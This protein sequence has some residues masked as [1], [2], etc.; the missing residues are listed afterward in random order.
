MVPLLTAA[1]NM[2]QHLAHGTSLVTVM[3]V[4]AAGLAGY[5]VTGNVDWSLAAWLALGSAVGAYF[6][7]VAM[8]RFPPRLLQFT[9]GLFLIAV[10]ARMFVT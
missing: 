1:L 10:A 3:F 5:W 4:A 6:G 2:P 9:F 7:A 8:M